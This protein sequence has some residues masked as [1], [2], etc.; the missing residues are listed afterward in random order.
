MGSR[1]EALAAAHLEAQGL[2][3]VARNFRCPLGELDLVAADAQ[4]LVFVEVKTRRADTEVHPSLSVGRRKQRK[5][6][7]LGEQFMAQHPQ[8]VLQPRF[9]VVAVTLGRDGAQ[10]EHIPNA[11]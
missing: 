11:F 10:V 6:R 8:W 9:D 1:G 5:V 7:Q 4:Y 3:I 2:R